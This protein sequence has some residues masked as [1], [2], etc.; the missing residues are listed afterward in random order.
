MLSLEIQGIESN[1]FEGTFECGSG[2][3]S[4]PDFWEAGGNWKLNYRASENDMA[5]EDN[6]PF[7]S[8][9]ELRKYDTQDREWN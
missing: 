9:S 5:A 1:C 3:S 4:E 8:V 7:G 2:W 6:A